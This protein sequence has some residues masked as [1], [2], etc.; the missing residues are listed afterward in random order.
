MNL[1]WMAWTMPTA[2]F[3]GSIAGALLLMTLWEK[4]RP[5]IRRRGLLPFATTRGDRFFL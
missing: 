4:I 5:T 2:I 1:S 3:F